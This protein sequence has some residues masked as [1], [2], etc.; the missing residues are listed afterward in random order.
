MRSSTRIYYSS[1]TTYIYL[2]KFTI[3]PGTFATIINILIFILTARPIGLFLYGIDAYA[4]V[5]LHH[6]NLGHGSPSFHKF[7]Q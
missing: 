7:I 2:H 5:I 6:T 3:K 1:A 4:I